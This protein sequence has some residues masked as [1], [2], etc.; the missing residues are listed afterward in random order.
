MINHFQQKVEKIDLIPANIK[1]NNDYVTKKFKKAVRE[2]ELNDKIHF[3][4]LRHSFAS[5]LVQRGASIYVAKELLG[6]SD[7][8]TTQIYSHLEQSN[9]KE[10][11]I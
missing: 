11:K 7:V 5:R 1:F 8:K 4:T 10:V 2:A 3:H 6:H 9:L